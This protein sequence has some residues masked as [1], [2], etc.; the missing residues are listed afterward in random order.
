MILKGKKTVKL[1]I[2]LFILTALCGCKTTDYLKNKIDK[3]ES[4]RIQ[5]EKYSEKAK[6]SPVWWNTRYGR[7]ETTRHLNTDQFGGGSSFSR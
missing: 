4:D 3:R 7:R 1:L 2:L 5:N 6:G